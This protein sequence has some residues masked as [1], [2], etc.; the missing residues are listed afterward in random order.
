MAARR[1]RTQRFKV[2]LLGEGRVGKTS[3]L[4]RFC[5][6]TFNDKQVPTLQASYLDRAVSVD[7]KQVQLSIWDTAGQERFHALGPIYYRD[8][9]AAL[10]VYDITDAETLERVRKWVQELKR[11]ASDNIVIAIAGNKCDLEKRRHVKQKDAEELAEAVGASH[12]HTS[13]KQNKGLKEAFKFLAKGVLKKS[14]ESGDASVFGGSPGSKSGRRQSLRGK[15]G[16][17]IREDSVGSQKE[18]GGGSGGCC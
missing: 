17:R 18:A 7:G 4:V 14:A 8:A 16:I 3:I 2:V 15:K 11:H 5:Q 6:N 10:L 1:T 12:F 13:A 9:D